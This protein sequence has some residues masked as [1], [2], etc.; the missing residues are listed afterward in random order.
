[1][2]NDSCLFCFVVLIFR[3]DKGCPEGVGTLELHLNVSSFAKSF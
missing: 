2:V 1:M 3:I